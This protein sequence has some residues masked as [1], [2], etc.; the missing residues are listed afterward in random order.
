MTSNTAGSQ[1][2]KTAGNIPVHNKAALCI[3]RS[4]N[5]DVNVQGAK[6]ATAKQKSR[7]E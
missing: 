7:Q 1:G 2:Q 5:L 4:D 3:G 6:H